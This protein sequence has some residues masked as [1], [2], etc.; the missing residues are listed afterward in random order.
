MSPFASYSKC[1]TRFWWLQ[2]YGD[3]VIS[4][5]WVL[6]LIQSKVPKI[7]VLVYSMEK[8]EAFFLVFQSLSYERR[9]YWFNR[10]LCLTITLILEQNTLAVVCG[11]L[12][13][14]VVFAQFKKREKHPWNSVNFTKV[15]GFSL[16]L[17]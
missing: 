11:A 14:L 5:L 12:R 2:S 1:H 8:G 9:I 4:I 15:A 13:D 17:Y 10:L 7:D 3:I 6:F 16:Q